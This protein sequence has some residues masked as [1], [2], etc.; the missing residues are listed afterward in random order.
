G[1]GLAYWL[2]VPKALELERKDREAGIIGKDEYLSSAAE[3]NEK[4]EEKS[5]KTQVM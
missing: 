2:S 1:I 5:S 3:E 4:V